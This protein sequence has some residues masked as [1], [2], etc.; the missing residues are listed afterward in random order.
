MVFTVLLL[1]RIHYTP[2]Y[3]DELPEMAIEIEEEGPKE[4]QLTEADQDMLLRKLHESASN[5]F[6]LMNHY[7]SLRT[8]NRAKKIWAWQW[9]TRWLCSSRNH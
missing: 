3:P 6:H 2:N 7:W 8:G 1:L 5:I 9:F 4:D